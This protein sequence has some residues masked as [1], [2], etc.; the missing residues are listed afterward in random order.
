MPRSGCFVLLPD[1]PAARLRGDAD[2]PVVLVASRPSRVG[3]C[4]SWLGDCP[5]T[6]TPPRGFGLCRSCPA[7]TEGNAASTEGFRARSG[8]FVPLPDKPAT[9]LRG[10]ADTP[11][12]LAASRLPLEGSARHGLGIAPPTYTPPRGFWLCWP[13]PAFAEGDAASAEGFHARSGCFV[14]LRDKPATRLLAFASR[15][16]TLKY[17]PSCALRV[18]PDD[19]GTYL[20]ADRPV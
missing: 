6:Y 15:R 10:D 16:K 9:R 11:V 20:C 2:S 18:F 19:R 12:V 5:A 1:K 3:G 17:R 4:S 14:P 7:F 13:C 8:C